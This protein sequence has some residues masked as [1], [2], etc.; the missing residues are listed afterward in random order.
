MKKVIVF[1]G[2]IFSLCWLWLAFSLRSLNQ[3][4]SLRME[5]DSLVMGAARPQA[6]KANSSLSLINSI[7]F[8]LLFGFIKETKTVQFSF[9]KKKR[10]QPIT[11][12]FFFID[13]NLRK[14]NQ[15]QSKR[16]NQTINGINQCF[17]L[18]E[19]FV[20][21]VSQHKKE[22]EEN[23]ET[24]LKDLWIVWWTRHSIWWNQIYY[25]SN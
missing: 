5:I 19:W 20:D 15:K 4:F 25:S 22:R 3:S 10:R 16:R 9:S 17:W 6:N 11:H 12:F 21:E 24:K 7:N 2:V 13:M 18:V 1:C 8:F 14:R 23:N